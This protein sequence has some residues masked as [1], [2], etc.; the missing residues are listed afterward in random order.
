MHTKVYHIHT[1]LHNP[2][3]LKDKYGE[4]AKIFNLK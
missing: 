4:A 1:A 2:I 3:W